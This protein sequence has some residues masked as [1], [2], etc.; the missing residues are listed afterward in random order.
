MSF[1]VKKHSYSNHLCLSLA[2]LLFATAAYSANVDDKRWFEIEVIVFKHKRADINE[3]LWPENNQIRFPENLKDVHTANLY[4]TPEGFVAPE[5]PEQ[6][7]PASKTNTTLSTQDGQ[8]NP[9]EILSEQELKLNN[10][11]QSLGK[12]S[13]YQMLAHYGWRQPVAD[14][15]EAEW[16]RIIGGKDYS[17][18]FLMNGSSVSESSMLSSMGISNANVTSLSQK[19]QPNF[20]D[21]VANSGSSTYSLPVYHAVPEI[22]GAIQVY[23]S[24]YLHI[25]TQLFMRI[26]G[27]A[28]LDISALSSN[29][30][31]SMLNMTEDGMLSSDFES[32]F[33]WSYD[34]GN[35]FTE[36]NKETLLIDKLLDYTMEQSRRVRSGEVHYFD[37]PLFGLIIEIRPLDTNASEIDSE[38]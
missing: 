1:V 8:H 5:S 21:S 32:G 35:A 2:S 29:L 15:K 9:F 10:L 14:K 17:S 36:S 16:V 22:D 26:P 7:E 20:N 12:S 30:S 13:L 38:Q 24:R 25:N 23:L 4:P 19:D 27:K 37:H 33:S 11:S 34:S 28:E 3:E 18:E 6:V 31:S